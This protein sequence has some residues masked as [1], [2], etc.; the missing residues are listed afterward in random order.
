MTFLTM[1]L[2]LLQRHHVT[3]EL[4]HGRGPRVQPPVA[5]DSNMLVCRDRREGAGHVICQR[6]G[7]VQ[8]SQSV[9]VRWK[10]FDF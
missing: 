5:A 8:D 4:V 7:V 6:P 9:R 10:E 3:P 1:P 2:S